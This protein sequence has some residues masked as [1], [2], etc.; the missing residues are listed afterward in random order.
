MEIA[1]GNVAARSSYR[2]KQ[3]AENPPPTITTRRD[4]TDPPLSGCDPAAARPE[5]CRS[6]GSLDMQ[7]LCLAHLS[8]L[9]PRNS[10]KLLI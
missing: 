9:D 2:A 10:A 5:A 3:A 6:A 4:C 7:E 8:Q 1:T